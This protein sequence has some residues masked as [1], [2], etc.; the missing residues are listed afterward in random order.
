MVLHV[1]STIWTS[2]S[3]LGCAAPQPCS[4]NMQM[5]SNTPWKQTMCKTCY[6]IWMIILLLAQPHSLV[7]TNNITTIIATCKELGFAINAD[8]ITNPATTPNFLGVDIDSV[9][10][11]ARINLTHLSETIS[12][13]KGIA[14]HW[15]AIKRSILSLIGKLHFVCQVC[16]PGRA[17]PC[18]M[19]ETSMKAQHLHHRIKLNQDLHRDVEWWLCY[20][21]SWNGV[22]LLYE[23]HWLTSTEFQLFTNASNIDFGC[24]FQGH[25]CQGWVSKHLLLLWA[26][27]H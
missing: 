4:M 3:L 27:E 21:P 25:W 1:T 10:M 16:R 20:L 19:I 18:C 26:Q 23:S 8:K 13:L 24:Y 6:T 2:F 9:A 22:S 14:G 15:S 17:F 12:L 5:A 7:C 11:E